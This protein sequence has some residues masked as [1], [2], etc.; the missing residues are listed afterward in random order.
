MSDP[1]APPPLR[2][3]AERLIDTLL[4]RIGKDEKAAKPH[5]WLAATILTLRDQI[6]DRWMES[7]VPCM[8]RGPSASIISAW[9][10]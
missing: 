9:N 5:D 8:L 2:P 3:F 4:H 1:I 7:P 6:I 10:S